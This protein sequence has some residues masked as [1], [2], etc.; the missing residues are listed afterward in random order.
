VADSSRELS[1]SSVEV[2]DELVKL[3]PTVPRER[4]VRILSRQYQG[5]I[6]SPELFKQYGEVIADAP[7]RILRVFEQDSEHVRHMQ[8][9]A[10]QAQREESRRVHWMAFALIAGGFVLAVLFAYMGKDL[11]AGGLLGTTLVGTIGGLLNSR[12]NGNKQ[13][14]DDDSDRENPLKRGQTRNKKKTKR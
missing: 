3:A 9:N 2:V 7:E 13:P 12:S 14:P 8:K 6:P 10:L 5:P 4:F 1:Q 11:L